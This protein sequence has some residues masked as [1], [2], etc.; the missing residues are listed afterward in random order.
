MVRNSHFGS[1]AASNLGAADG[2]AM[3]LPPAGRISLRAGVSASLQVWTQA[4]V[5]GATMA[6]WE[7]GSGVRISQ[8]AGF[9]ETLATLR[10]TAPS[11][12]VGRAVTTA[13]EP[14][15][16]PPRPGPGAPR[17]EGR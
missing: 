9:R 13:Q 17:W 1:E 16:P 4:P 8:P 3:G 12:A 6:E 10:S 7:P 15:G 11:P 2:S 5:C 14:S